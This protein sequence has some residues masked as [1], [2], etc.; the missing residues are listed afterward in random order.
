MW[1]SK[2]Q[3]TSALSSAE[4]EYLASTSGSDVLYLRTLL[5]QL[6]FAQQS[7]TPVYED[8]TACIEW[9]NN[10]IGGRERAKHIDI[11]KHFAHEVIQCGLLNFVRVPTSDQ[12]AGILTKG[13]H[14]QQWQACVKGRPSPS[15]SL[16][17]ERL[18][19]SQCLARALASQV[20]ATHPLK[21][22]R[23]ST[24]ESAVGNLRIPTVAVYPSGP[25]KRGRDTK[26][27][28]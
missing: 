13:L 25:I 12:L 19:S 21:G 26:R 9:R 7:P 6:G 1:R 17:S 4:A 11:R 18:D 8:N 20:M 24:C 2:M 22:R 10:I 28:Y 27:R 3:K 15:A 23:N 16:D 5:D 14:H